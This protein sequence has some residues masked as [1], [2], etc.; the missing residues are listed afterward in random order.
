MPK[1]TEAARLHCVYHRSGELVRPSPRQRNRETGTGA[2]V[3]V[4]VAHHERRAQLHGRD[5][6]Q[7]PRDLSSTRCRRYRS[8]RVKRAVVEEATEAGGQLLGGG[9]P[10]APVADHLHPEAGW[11]RHAS[12]LPQH[13]ARLVAH[14]RSSFPRGRSI[15]DRRDD[16]RGSASTKERLCGLDERVLPV[17]RSVDERGEPLRIALHLPLR[18]QVQQLVVR[19]QPGKSLAG[20]R[21][22][23]RDVSTYPVLPAA[24]GI[25]CK[26]ELNGVARRAGGQEHRKCVDPVGPQ[27]DRMEANVVERTERLANDVVAGTIDGEVDI[28][29]HV[30]E[31]QAFL[32]VENREANTGARHGI[33]CEHRE[34]AVGRAHSASVAAR[35][36][37]SMVGRRSD[38]RS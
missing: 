32:V 8:G 10:V 19:W 12:E 1:S 35:R 7:P 31:R 18:H 28:R 38:G 14:R 5:V 15:K 30:A 23:E 26:V 20:N 21:N 25:V 16:V 3:L 17:P 11:V 24:V 9:R 6:T 2:E 29:R 36:C 27:N 13:L 22:V 37:A 4:G 34:S 33:E